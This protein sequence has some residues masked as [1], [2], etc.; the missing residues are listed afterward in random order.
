LE[1]SIEVCGA[2]VV[3]VMFVFTTEVGPWPVA[4]AEEQV[5]SAGSPL[6]VNVMAVVKL[7]DAMIPTM[8]VPDDPGA[9]TETFLGPDTPANPGWIV[10]VIGVAL[11]LGVKLLSPR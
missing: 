5:A 6:Q 11:L 3:I 1:C 8:V 7:L 9:L 4:G 10:K 2:V